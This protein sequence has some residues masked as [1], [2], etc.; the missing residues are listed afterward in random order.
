MQTSSGYEDFLIY[1]DQSCLDN[2]DKDERFGINEGTDNGAVGQERKTTNKEKEEETESREEKIKKLKL[3]VQKQ[4]KAV[5]KLKPTIW[6]YRPVSLHFKG[7][8][9]KNQ[10]HK[11]KCLEREKRP[12]KGGLET[13]ARRQKRRKIEYDD[14][15]TNSRDVDILMSRGE[16]I[17]KD[18]FL[19][20]I[21]LNRVAKFHENQ[22]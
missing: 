10:P 9:G 8:L 12:S 3:L 5:D 11:T 14:T 4:E 17:T 1:E 16:L 22:S 7:A 21:G 15:I 20:V 2:R 18:E 6:N 13:R 19:A